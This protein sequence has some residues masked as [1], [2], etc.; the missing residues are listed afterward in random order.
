MLK[1]RIA[2]VWRYRSG[3]A[4]DRP[5]CLASA[6]IFAELAKVGPQYGELD[7]RGEAVQLMP[8]HIIEPHPGLRAYP[9]LSQARSP[10]VLVWQKA[11]KV[12]CIAQCRS[13]KR[14]CRSWVAVCAPACSTRVCSRVACCSVLAP[15]VRC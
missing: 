7:E 8:F 2:G 9:F 11:Q 4:C 15:V 12:G 13:H 14:G 6:Q 3:G 1:A 10:A 5:S